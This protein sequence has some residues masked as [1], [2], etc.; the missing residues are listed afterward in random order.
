MVCRVAPQIL[1]KIPKVRLSRRSPNSLPF[2][3]KLRRDPHP[4][5][6]PVPLQVSFS[7][8]HHRGCCCCCSLLLLPR[9]LGAGANA[10]HARLQVVERRLRVRRRPG[11]D[12]ARRRPRGPR[13][14]G[15][16]IHP[17]AKRRETGARRRETGAARRRRWGWGWGGRRRGFAPL[18][19]RQPLAV[20]LRC[21]AL[22][23]RHR[24]RL[25]GRLGDAAPAPRRAPSP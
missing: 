7:S 9:R 10:F 5:R 25:D 13:L 22:H 11:R 18:D 8:S 1:R 19:P 6:P 14:R 17:L 2:L 12:D 21:C 15:D 16:T 20:H 23:L 24:A 4:I 3:I